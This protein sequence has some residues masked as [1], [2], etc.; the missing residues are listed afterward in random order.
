MRWLVHNWG[1]KLVSLVLATF[2]WIFVRGITNE[3]R[4]VQS[5]PLEIRP[6]SSLALLSAS[7]SA[8]N[9]VVSGTRDDVRQ[10]S[11]TDLSALLDLSRDDRVGEFQVP[12][13][14]RS[15]RHPPRLQVVQVDPAQVL[16]R[17][18]EMIERDATVVPQF[19][20]DAAGGL[21]IES[22]SVKPPQ[23]R[24]R[25]PKK[26]LETVVTLETLPVVLTGRRSSFR[27]RIEVALPDPSVV[28]PQR[29][30]VE[31]DV[32]LGEPKPA[33]NGGSMTNVPAGRGR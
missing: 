19:E 3:S 16:V 12:I 22:F 20:G 29:R 31:V 26:V 30:W 18:D 27:E 2:T 32:R 7:V 4:I 33:E 23:V 13:P 11:R 5:V 9:V 24:V 14:L 17:V 21:A 6:R 25:G 28:L 10:A 1:L 8:V 15:V